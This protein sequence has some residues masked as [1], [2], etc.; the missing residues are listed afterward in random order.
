[1]AVADDDNDKAAALAVKSKA[2]I[3]E[4]NT[5]D[6]VLAV[7]SNI[8]PASVLGEESS[9]VPSVT[10]SALQLVSEQVRSLIILS[11]LC[12]SNAIWRNVREAHC[13]QW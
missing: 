11:R 13:L 9:P 12:N 5:D 6:S 4:N 3:T 1:M 10:P 7:A 8:V 2:G